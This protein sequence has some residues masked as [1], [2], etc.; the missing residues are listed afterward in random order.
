MTTLLQ[1]LER[2]RARERETLRLVVRDRLRAAL[3]AVYPAGTQV[4]VFG[5]LVRAGRFDE[6]S[7]VDVAVAAP[8]AGRSLFWLQGE[9]EARVGLAV[10]ALLLDET[11]LRPK[12]EREGELW[13][14]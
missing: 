6:S 10:D 5:S 4:W 14:L 8:P 7:D 13:T 3:R 2:T 1:E 12:I 11:R 9:L